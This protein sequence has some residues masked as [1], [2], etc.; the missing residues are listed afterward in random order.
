MHNL[1]M[2]VVTNC[3][4]LFTKFSVLLDIEKKASVAVFYNH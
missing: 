3:M 1:I 2:Q 4:V